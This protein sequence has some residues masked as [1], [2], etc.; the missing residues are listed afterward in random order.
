MESLIDAIR[1]AIAADAPP[2]ARIAAIDA[3]RA[4]MTALGAT[5]GEPILAAVPENPLAAIVGALRGVPPDQLLDLAIDKLRA[6]L[7]AGTDV[8]AVTPVKFHIVPLP[9]RGRRP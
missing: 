1:V 3:C 5:P 7:P 9:D 8:P 6:A 4:I 2:E